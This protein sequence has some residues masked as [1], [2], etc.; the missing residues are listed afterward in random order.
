MTGDDE[1]WGREGLTAAVA[2]RCTLP[3]GGIRVR[4][5]FKQLAESDLDANCFLKPYWHR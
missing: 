1:S 5:L 4:S 2:H 3:P